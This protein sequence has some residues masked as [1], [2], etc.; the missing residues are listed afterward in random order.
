MTTTTNQKLRWPPQFLAWITLLHVLDVV[1]SFLQP[2]HPSFASGRTLARIR[3]VPEQMTVWMARRRCLMVLTHAIKED[4]SDLMVSDKQLC[5][6]LPHGHFLLGGQ[7]EF[8][9]ASSKKE[10][11]DWTGQVLRQA[12]SMTFSFLGLVTHNPKSLPLSGH[13]VT[14]RIQDLTQLNLGKSLTDSTT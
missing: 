5:N 7:R 8:E 1:Q 10:P 6:K 11:I 2:L 3:A 13:S 14:K 12:G 9:G 4:S